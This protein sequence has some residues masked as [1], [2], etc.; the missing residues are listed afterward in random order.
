M[1]WDPGQEEGA[2]DPE[3]WMEAWDYKKHYGCSGVGADSFPR[4]CALPFITTGSESLYQLLSQTSPE[5]MHRNVAQYGL[6]P[7]TR[8]PNLNLR[9]VTPKQVRPS[10]LPS[11]PL[12][13]ITSCSHARSSLPS[14]CPSGGWGGSALP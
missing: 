2:G 6:D 13:Q 11:R 7:A 9:A 14:C 5:N 4:V 10:T 3:I 12:S 8:Y 1:I